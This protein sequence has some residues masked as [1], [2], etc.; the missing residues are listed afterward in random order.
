M[1]KDAEENAKIDKSKKSI[2]NITYELD[3]LLMKAEK[4][5]EFLETDQKVEKVEKIYFVKILNE[6]KRLY[7]KKQLN[8]SLES[9]NKLK[10]ACQFLTSFYLRKK[11]DNP[12]RSVDN[13][14][15]DTD[16]NS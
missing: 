1:I 5:L 13:K 3:N 12:S 15:I 11:L 4:L 8:K 10:V 6:M 16:F 9:L 2:V 14:V 7:R